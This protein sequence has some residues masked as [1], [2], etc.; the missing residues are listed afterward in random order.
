[1]RKMH[2]F[3][4][5]LKSLVTG[6]SAV[7]RGVM[8]AMPAMFAIP[9]AFA[10]NFPVKPVRVIVA[11]PPGGS[12]DLLARYIAPKMAENLGQSFV[13]ENRPGGNSNIAAEHVARATPDGYTI[14]HTLDSTLTLNGA[15]YS[16]VPFDPIKDFAPLSRLVTGNSLLVVNPG[17]PAR[18]LRE[19]IEHAKANPGKLNYGATAASTQISAEQMKALFGIKIV[20]IPYKG[21]AQLVP[22]LATGEIHIV[23]DGVTNYVPLIKEGKLRAIATFA[24]GRD[25]LL[26]NVPGVRES[27]FPELERP[28]WWAWFATGGTPR[29][30]VTRLNQA[31]VWS[32]SQPD[33]RE[34]ILGIGLQPSSSTPDELAQILA[35]DVAKWGALIKTYGIKGD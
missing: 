29:P 4:S 6:L 25:L 20:H 14:F 8:F 27:G 30:V 15:L 1:M 11:F 33:L 26:P 28:T 22:A 18:N 21:T 23:I 17:V 35:A 3:Q 2:P 10:Q 32:L 12:V 24:P 31:L 5:R 16:N 9:P 13:V 7:A 34:K 19:L